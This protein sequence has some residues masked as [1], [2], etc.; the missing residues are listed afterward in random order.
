MIPGGPLDLSKSPFILFWEITRACALA[1]RHCRATAFKKPDPAQLDHE[2]ST[3]LLDEI[4]RLSPRMLVLTGGDPMMRSDL[5]ELIRYASESLGIHTSLSPSATEL[6]LRTN[7]HELKAAGIQ[8][9]SLSLDGATRES[10]DSFR[11]VKHTFY[12]TLAAVDRAYEAGIPVQINTTIHRGNIGELDA[13]ADLMYRLLPAMWSVF[14][15]V[16]TGRAGIDDLPDAADVEVMLEK[17]YEIARD[18]PFDVKTTEAHH[19]RR[20]VVQHERSAGRVTRRAPPGIRD[21]RGVAFISHTGEISPS[22]F[23]PVVAG[24][25]REDSLVDVYRNHPLFTGLRDHDR[26]KGKCGDCEF[27]ALCGGSRSRALAVYGDVF[28]EDPLCDFQPAI[29]RRGGPTS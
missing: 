19:Y 16:P 14:L 25:V 10:H 11:G 23:L 6:L 9:M 26:L 1:C 20:I 5:L 21:G 2:E 7:F 29:S 3:R 24:S 27:H 18:A 13:F 12:R 17:L 8:R 22:G 4:A 28:A 15:I